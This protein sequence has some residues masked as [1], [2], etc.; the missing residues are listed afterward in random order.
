MP[1]R[2]E[3]NRKTN[4]WVARSIPV[5]LL[6]LIGYASWVLT[7]LICVDYLINPPPA[8]NAIHR[9]GSAVAVLIT[10]YTLLILLLVSYARLLD[11]VVRRPGLVPRGPQWYAEE[12][13]TTT[14]RKG[15]RWARDGRRSDDEKSTDSDVKDAKTPKEIRVLANE[16]LPFRVEDFWHKD[17]FVCNPDGR[18]SFCSAC[19][20]WKPDRSHHC[21]ELNRCVMKFDHFCPWVGGVV[22]ETS[23]K[24]F[25]Q[26]TFYAALYTFQI[27][28]VSAY[29]FTERHRQTDFL[30]AHWI[31]LIAVAGLFLLFSAGMCVSTGQFAVINSGTV[32]NLSR[33]TKVWHLAVYI[34]PQGVREAQEKGIPLQL[35]SYPRPAEEMLGA[36]QQQHPTNRLEDSQGLGDQRSSN[37]PMRTFAILTSEPGD[38]PFDIGAL[39]NFQDIMGYTVWEWLSPVKP[40]PCSKHD[41][42]VS[43]YKL[44]ATVNSMKAKTGLSEFSSQSSGQSSRR[45]HR[46]SVKRTMHEGQ[47][48]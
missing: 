5:L 3:A 48:T 17:V 15:S 37:I 20:N 38:N 25:I 41:S 18:P 8:I 29:F 2:T 31:V 14:N 16:T 36:P 43:L 32:E 44:G 6:A 23:F 10:Y 7:K 33:K 47:R 45:K 35:I 39:R 24:F 28:V 19:H 9:R 1:P 34:S 27:L 4:I 40:S 11:I 26:F 13:R 46:N 22:S 30:N 21:S 42:E 12:Q